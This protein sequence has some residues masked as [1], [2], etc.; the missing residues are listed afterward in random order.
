MFNSVN[1][2]CDRKFRNEFMSYKRVEE[3]SNRISAEHNLHVIENPNLSKGTKNRY[4]KPTKRDGFT[5]L[6][7]KVF[8]A[9]SPKDFDDFLKQL[10]KN[11]CKIRRRGKTISVKPPGAERFFRFKS[12]KKGLPDGYDEESLRKKI[13]D[14]QT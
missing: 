4:K 5:A 3:I 9:D 13:A 2:D 7:D 10:E 1:L 14:M 12:G 6:I 11:G 8:A